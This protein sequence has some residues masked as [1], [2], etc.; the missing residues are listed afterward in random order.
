MKFKLYDTRVMGY[1]VTIR[2]FTIGIYDDSDDI[3]GQDVPNKI[4]K[5]LIDEGFCDSWLDDDASI[6]VNIYKHKC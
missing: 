3:E 4:V 5:Y 6:K 2:P 1:K